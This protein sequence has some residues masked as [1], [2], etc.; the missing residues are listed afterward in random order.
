MHVR[1]MPSGGAV[2]MQHPA[3]LAR[4]V[5]CRQRALL[6]GR[7]LN[8]P[9]TMMCVYPVAWQVEGVRRALCAASAALCEARQVHPTPT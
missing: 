6:V 9:D 2:L 7:A 5:R 3:R 4:D 1:C 8:G